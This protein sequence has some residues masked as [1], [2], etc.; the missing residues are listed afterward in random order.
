VEGELG[1]GGMGVVYRARHLRLNRFVALKMLLAGAF[2]RP[3]ERDRFLRE[4]QALAALGH[5][6]VVQVHEFGELDGLPYFTMEYVE[7]AA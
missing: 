5:P 7:G 4:A 3:E 6:N 2:A 1:R